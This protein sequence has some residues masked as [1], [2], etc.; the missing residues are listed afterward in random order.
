M[1]LEVSLLG[2]L[3]ASADGLPLPL[4]GAG[5]RGEVALARLALEAGRTVSRDALAEALWN[6]RLPTSWQSSVRNVVTKLRRS[7]GIPI[8]S[9]PGGYRLDAPVV[10]DLTEAAAALAEAEQALQ[11][12]DRATAS[13]L[14]RGILETTSRTVLPRASGD[15]VD[16]VRE[17]AV[18]LSLRAAAVAA[19]AAPEEA[20]GLVRTTAE[21]HPYRDDAMRVLMRTLAATGDPVGAIAAYEAFRDRLARDCWSAPALETQV[22]HR[23]LVAAE[24]EWQAARDGTVVRWRRALSYGLPAARAALR[25]RMFEDVITVAT[26]T[27]NTL[28]RAG[29]PAPEARL[30]LEILLGAAKR[31]IGDPTGTETLHATF[32]A[33]ERTGDAVRMADAALAFTDG[34]TL[35]CESFIDSALP[36]R[37]EA[38]LAALPEPEATRRAQLLG[39]V[40]EAYAF[41]SDGKAAARARAGAVAALAQ[42]SDP[43]ARATVLLAVRRSLHGTMRLADQRAAEQELPRLADR[44]DDDGLRLRAALAS[45]T[46]AVERGDGD[47]LEAL[48]DCAAGA[49]RHLPGGAHHHALAYAQASLVMLRGD[50]DRAE[51]L[52]EAAAVT[53]RRQG[54]DPTVVEAT[55]LSQL[56]SLRTEQGRFDELRGPL[57]DFFARAPVPEWWRKLALHAD[58]TVSDVDTILDGYDA[59]GFTM[60]QTVARLA[61]MADAVVALGHRPQ[62]ARLHAMVAPHGGGGGYMV[63]FLGP[64]DFHLG[65][66]ERALGDHEGAAA[67]FRAAAAF[68]RRLGSPHWAG[69][70]EAREPL[71]AA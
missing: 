32:A 48:L 41:G 34:G 45:Y 66:L 49:A 1:R 3:R 16:A 17:Q 40:A 7:L 22:L 37:Y 47:R 8:T 31:A 24:R 14:A 44:L 38:A 39:R 58:L 27:L 53:G 26:R 51:A 11:A 68:A 64:I 20:V 2:H 55:R 25:A 42:V 30:D 9:V 63:A 46:T 59:I 6:D 13:A 29:D 62:I 67:R 70:D 61:S 4:D 60:T 21:D 33:A 57:R 18:G 56:V 5:V 23:D 36:A 43:H 52:V 50:H 12:G 54:E 28:A 71:R 10:V 19:E 69:L 15:W 35:H 65:V